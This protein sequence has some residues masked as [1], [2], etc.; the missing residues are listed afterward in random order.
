[1]ITKVTVTKDNYKDVSLF[2]GDINVIFLQ[3]LAELVKAEFETLPSDFREKY[4]AILHNAY[5]FEE[6]MFNHTYWCYTDIIEKAEASDYEWVH[7]DIEI[8]ADSLYK[9]DYVDQELIEERVEEYF[10]KKKRYG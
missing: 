10:T 6:I 7:K 1:M 4:V 9:N 5:T 3:S 2:V 8:I